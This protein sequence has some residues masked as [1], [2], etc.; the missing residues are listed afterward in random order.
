MHRDT[1]LHR[2][3]ELNG[4]YTRI[5]ERYT[6]DAELVAQLNTAQPAAYVVV[7][8]RYS[9]PDC[10]RS[11]PRMTRIAE[12]LPGWGW[13]IFNVETDREREKALEIVRIPTFIVYDAAG[14][15]ELGRIIERPASGSL[16]RDLLRIVGVPG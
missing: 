1:A 14:G 2:Y 12:G 4:T 11:V 16:V 15:R 3:V 9:C 7:A 5:Y 13:D 8:S 6:T 10:A